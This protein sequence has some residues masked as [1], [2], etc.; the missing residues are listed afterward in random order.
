MPA[1]AV[2]E[3]DVIPTRSDS[4]Q[5]FRAASIEFISSLSSFASD[6]NNLG[7]WIASEFPELSSTISTVPQA[8]AYDD[9][10]SVF[11]PEYYAFVDAINRFVLQLNQV[12][13]EIE[14]NTI[15][16]MPLKPDI[17]LSKSAFDSAAFNWIDAAAS[18]PTILNSL[19]WT[20]SNN[21]YTS[22][23]FWENGSEFVVYEWTGSVWQTPYIEGSGEVGAQL[24][25]ITNVMAANYGWQ[26]SFRP[27]SIRLIV[28]SSEI[29]EEITF[30]LLDANDD[31]IAIHVFDFSSGSSFDVTIPIT[32]GD[33]DIARILFTSGPDIELISFN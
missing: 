28:S 31:V 20:V 25:P 3:F 27:I 15:S 6:I 30:N 13:T 19:S 24:V 22:D 17:S 8:P 14:L 11:D 4:L 2:S 5:A 33:F 18:L 12:R 21:N 16:P 9:S 1:P 10:K 26:D 29:E 32:F 23:L 7:Q